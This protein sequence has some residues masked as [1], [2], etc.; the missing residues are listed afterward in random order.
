M[1]PVSDLPASETPLKLF[2]PQREP[3]I[4][5]GQ[6]DFVSSFFLWDSKDLP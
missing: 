1:P 4:L 6:P 3:K 2:R 5:R